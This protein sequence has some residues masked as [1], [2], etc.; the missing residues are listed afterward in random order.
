MESMTQWAGRNNKI[1][2]DIELFLYL[3]AISATMDALLMKSSLSLSTM[4]IPVA[5]AA[6]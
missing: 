2:L 6:R 1:I 3:R 5:E 4:S